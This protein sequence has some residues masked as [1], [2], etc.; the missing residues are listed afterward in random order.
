LETEIPE[1][2]TQEVT[3]LRITVIIPVYNSTEY[4]RR[5]I[6]SV[7][8]QSFTDYEILLIDDGSTDGSGDVCDGY[9]KRY[10]RVRVIHQKHEGVSSACNCG[11]DNAHGNYLMFCDSDDYVE[12]DWIETLYRE[13]Q[14][15]PNS[16]VFSGFYKEEAGSTKSLLLSNQSGNSHIPI[17][18]YYYL[19]RSGF[20][21]YRWNR[22][23][24]REKVAGKIRFDENI[25][26]GEDVLFNIEYLK[27]CDSFLYVDKPL[28]HWVNNGNNSLSRAYHAKYYDDIK[29][30]YFPRASAIA[31]TDLQEFYNDYFYRFYSCVDVV[32]DARNTMTDKEKND[33]IRYILHDDAFCHAME[34]AESSRL[35]MLLRLKSNMIL[36]IYKK[37]RG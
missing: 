10:D 7:L 37:L 26:V 9:A 22:I 30:L 23:F 19:Y 24:L 18:E 25:S 2:K 20:S 4:L 21:A 15:H 16:F 36:R 1:I 6:D 5:C 35:K 27:T 31:D 28:Y 8:N 14:K 33:Y 29:K 12:P 13:A 34:H 32:N 17:T 3:V 11:I